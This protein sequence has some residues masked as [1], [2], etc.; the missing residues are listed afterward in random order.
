MNNSALSP[1]P[2]PIPLKLPVHTLYTLLNNSR[3]FSKS[4]KITHHE[5]SPDGETVFFHLDNVQELRLEHYEEVRSWGKYRLIH[6]CNQVNGIG[7]VS[8]KGSTVIQTTLENLI[9]S[10]STIQCPKGIY[11]ISIFILLMLVALLCLIY[12][13]GFFSHSH[14][15]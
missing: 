1:L 15:I 3:H 10:P 8:N 14:H 2:S 13:H 4:I 5:L 6:Y 7:V 11:L 9:Q 12:R